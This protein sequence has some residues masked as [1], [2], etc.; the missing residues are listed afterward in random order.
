VEDATSEFGSGSTCHS[1]F[2]QWNGIGIFKNIWIR[3]L[4]ECENRKGIKWIWQ[5]IDSKSL[6]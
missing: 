1:R 2:Q 6:A 4:K 5:S 3:L